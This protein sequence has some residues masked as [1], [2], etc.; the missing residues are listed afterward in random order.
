MAT[1]HDIAYTLTEAF[2]EI[3]VEEVLLCKSQDETSVSATKTAFCSFASPQAAQSAL[4]KGSVRILGMEVII[5]PLDDDSAE[6]AC[7]SS[8]DSVLTP[9]LGLR[10]EVPQRM[11]NAA[12]G[13]SSNAKPHY[14]PRAACAPASPAPASIPTSAAFWGT[15]MSPGT[16][17]VQVQAAYPSNGFEMF[18]DKGPMNSRFCAPTMRHPPSGGLENAQF[19]AAMTAGPPMCMMSHPMSPMAMHPVWYDSYG[20]QF[21]YHQGTP[22]MPM[23]PAM[24]PAVL[25]GLQM[26]PPVVCMGQQAAPLPPLPMH[27]AQMQSSHLT[28]NGQKCPVTNG[29]PSQL[30]GQQSP[31]EVG[32]R[33]RHNKSKVRTKSSQGEMPSHTPVVLGRVLEPPFMGT[34]ITADGRVYSIEQERGEEPYNPKTI[35]HPLHTG[36]PVPTED[37][38]IADAN[39]GDWRCSGCGNLNFEFRNRCNL[40]RR[41]S[42]GPRPERPRSEVTVM[43]AEVPER[44]VA[45]DIVL[46]L[47]SMHG[48]LAEDG[49]KFWTPQPTCQHQ[50]K[51]RRARK[52]SAC[53]SA[54]CQFQDP[55]AATAAL[56]SGSVTI[57]D[58]AVR[59][60][61]AYDRVG[62]AN[63]CAELENTI[64]ASNRVM[65]CA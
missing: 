65:P 53:R 7:L 56:E 50:S 39:A 43:L 4:S 48:P 5:A 38:K 52:H 46:A 45:S 36:Q 8:P 37:C 63:C 55:E 14:V 30:N 34:E 20:N 23:A 47:S 40:C 59:I 32:S 62:R 31:K 33:R 10:G 35:D 9:S 13:R 24:A 49:V 26:Q 3:G 22:V 61:P 15:P 17:Y 19:C 12:K 25:P 64:T 27:N 28:G 51:N 11:N 41:P 29:Y 2:G 60:K 21:A 42:I 1:E 54:F 44:C 57:L 16:G 58:K 6:S 18:G